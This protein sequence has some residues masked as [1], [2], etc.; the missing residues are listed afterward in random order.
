MYVHLQDTAKGNSESVLMVWISV[1]V[2]DV[3]KAALLNSTII[4]FNVSTII[5]NLQR[6]E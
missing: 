6:L 3:I 5:C 2:H 1:T 4:G